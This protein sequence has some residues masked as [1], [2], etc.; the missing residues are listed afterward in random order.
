[1]AFN[2]PGKSIQS[3][4]SGHSS[5]LKMVAEQRAASALK[6]VQKMKKGFSGSV[7]KTNKYLPDSNSK[8]SSNDAYGGDKTWGQGQKDSGGTL[9]DTTKQQ[10]AY[11]KEMKANDPKWNKRDDNDWKKRQNKINAS[12]GSSKVYDTIDDKKT[13]TQTDSRGTNEVMKGAGIKNEKTLL[14]VDKQKEI[15]KRDGL[16]DEID[17]AKENKNLD[18]RDIA[19]GKLRES[20]AGGDDEYTGTVVSRKVAKVRGSINKKQL[21]MR[22]NKRNRLEKRITKRKE[23]G[24]NT[25]K[26]E[27][28]YE[29]KGGDLSKTKNSENK[30]TTTE[31]KGNK[32][33]T[34][35]TKSSEEKLGNKTTFM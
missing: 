31:T 7:S 26:L 23:K 4:T 32:D 29:K 11:E 13:V 17:K 25:D 34:K 30:S 33:L 1:M 10:R 8:K 22:E 16:N 9:N 12:L 24:K 18:E 35:N 15:I 3:G 14:K 28:R 21:S 27:K 6:E 5:A 19:Q 20:Q 2:L